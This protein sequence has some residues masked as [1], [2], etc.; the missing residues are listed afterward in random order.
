[1]GRARWGTLAAVRS[2]ALS[3]AERMRLRI[4]RVVCEGVDERRARLGKKEGKVWLEKV[5]GMDLRGWKGMVVVVVVVE[6]YANKKKSRN[7]RART[8]RENYIQGYI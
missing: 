4:A 8:T 2:D 6:Y 1:M 3:R 5:C 7:E